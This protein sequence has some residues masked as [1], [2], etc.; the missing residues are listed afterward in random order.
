MAVIAQVAA[1]LECNVFLRGP[2]L[3]GC[4]QGVGTSGGWRQFAAECKELPMR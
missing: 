1:S 4:C 3:P 2:G